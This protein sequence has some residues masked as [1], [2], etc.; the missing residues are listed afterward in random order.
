MYTEKLTATALNAQKA[1]DE[2][3]AKNI[4]DYELYEQ[5]IDEIAENFK[6]DV[7][8]SP[9]DYDASLPTFYVSN[10]GDDSNDGKTPETPWK[11]LD[12]INDPDA[13]PEHC[14][15]LFR[16]GDT[17]RGCIK[18]PHAYI[19][20]SAYGE[21]KKPNLFG[22]MRNYADPSLWQKTE[23]PHV[24]YTD[25]C[26]KNIGIC[27][28]NHSDEYGR[29]D[30]VVAYRCVQG[31]R[32]FEG[33]Q[34]FTR[35]LDYWSEVEKPGFYLRCEYGN[36]GEVFD[37]IE[38]GERLNLITGN[39]HIKIDN[40]CVKYSGAHGVG[41][42]GTT[43]YTVQNCI[44]CYLGGSI[45]TGFNGGNKVGY[46]N[47]VQAYCECFGYYVNGNWIYQIY[48]TAI[49]H[50]FSGSGSDTPNHMKDVEY[51]GNLCEYCHWSIEYYNP[52][53]LKDPTTPRTVKNVNVSHNILRMGCYG[54]GSRGREDNG[55]LFNSFNLTP[56]TENFEAH[57]NIMDRCL[58]KMVRL[59][60]GGDEKLVASDNTFIQQEG[61]A[62]GWCYGQNYVFTK[63]NAAKYAKE[64]FHDKSARIIFAKA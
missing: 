10:S 14:N 29:Y 35:N 4:T 51:I 42:G 7:I 34:N 56:E 49:T 6:Q 40:L 62:F 12:K 43:D 30:E 1:I 17:W 3:N 63:E 32:G 39:D 13:T 53:S 33:P 48:D 59:N 21:G 41:I 36:P 31:V 18:P 26:G 60:V 44:F 38:L 8:N 54:W 20:Y 46:G 16:R 61:R 24:W 9:S 23:Y 27:A 22:S 15:I 5:G 11:T 57:S 25:A 19:T 37:S 52:A 64:H 2:L 58:G 50:Q 47:A 28:I 55:A 45:L